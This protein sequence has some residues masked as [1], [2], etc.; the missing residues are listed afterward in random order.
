M[1][2]WKSKKGCKAL[3]SEAAEAGVT[4]FYDLETTGLSKDTDEI[5]QF[6]GIKAVPDRLGRFY[7]MDELSLY[8]R[9]HDPIAEKIET[10]TGITNGFLKDKPSAKEQLPI[11]SAFLAGADSVAG[12]NNQKFDDPF[13]STALERHGL[14]GLPGRS[15]DVYLMVRDFFL[16]GRTKDLKLSSVAEYYHAVPEDARFHNALTDVRAAMGSLAGLLMELRNPEDNG[17][18]S[19]I[20]ELSSIRYWGGN[21]HKQK[22]LYVRSNAG[23]FYYDVAKRAWTDDEDGKVIRALDMERVQ[24]DVIQRAGAKDMDTAVKSYSKH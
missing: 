9:P 11:I 10:L 22:R 1:M 6:A 21:N 20:P 17:T 4:V 14:S 23:T 16:P 12:Y 5:I 19:L 18:G 13:L 8:I 15:L 24:E 3:F 2:G 7:I